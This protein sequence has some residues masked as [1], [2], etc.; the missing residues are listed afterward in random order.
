[1]TNL[2]IKKYASIWV[3]IFIHFDDSL[4]SS[5]I[6]YPSVCGLNVDNNFQNLKNRDGYFSVSVTVCVYRLI[7][8]RAI[9]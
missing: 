6:F 4:G 5:D 9:G 3:I 7:A 1:M 8:I 2:S